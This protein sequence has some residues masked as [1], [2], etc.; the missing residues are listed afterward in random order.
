MGPTHGFSWENA[1]AMRKTTT[2]PLPAGADPSSCKS[3]GCGKR[4]PQCDCNEACHKYKDCCADYKDQCSSDYADS[5]ATVD[6]ETG[7]GEAKQ[8]A[9]GKGSQKHKMS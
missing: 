1:K 7:S 4:G 3:I 6:E 2:T 5:P 8:E 9:H